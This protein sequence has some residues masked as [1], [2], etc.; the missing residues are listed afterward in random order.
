LFKTFDR[1]RV[2]N[3][4]A[5]IYKIKIRPLLD[6]AVNFLTEIFRVEPDFRFT[7]NFSRLLASTKQD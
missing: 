7:D 5:E 6:L 1:Q 2:F 3:C 4:V